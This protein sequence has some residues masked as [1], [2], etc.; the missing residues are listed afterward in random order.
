MKIS[1]RD[2]IIDRMKDNIIC[3]GDPSKTL[4]HQLTMTFEVSTKHRIHLRTVGKSS[5]SFSTRLAR[6]WR[7]MEV[8]LVTGKLKFSPLSLSLSFSFSSSLVKL[9][10]RSRKNTPEQIDRIEINETKIRKRK[11]SSLSNSRPTKNFRLKHD[12]CFI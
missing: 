10:R 8:R 4:Q 11:T 2:N 6:F 1:F 7:L 9:Y 3:Y 5:S 12:S